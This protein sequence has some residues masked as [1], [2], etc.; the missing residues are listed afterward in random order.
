MF[1]DLSNPN[2]LK[3]VFALSDARIQKR[4]KIGSGEFGVVADKQH[5]DILMVPSNTE[6]LLNGVIKLYPNDL[7]KYSRLEQKNLI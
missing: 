2:S 4:I 3:N 1:L 6:I 7:T 5:K